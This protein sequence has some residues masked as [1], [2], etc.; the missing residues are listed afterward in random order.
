M[1]REYVQ[2][3]INSVIP[4][5]K[6]RRLEKESHDIHLSYP[7]DAQALYTPPPTMSNIDD[8]ERVGRKRTGDV[9]SKNAG[10][11]AT[12]PSNEAPKFPPAFPPLSVR[13]L[14]ERLGG[15][16]SK[17]RSRSTSPIK[18]RLD[19][20]RLEK[21]VRIDGLEDDESDTLPPDIQTL[22][23]QLLLID[24]P[25]HGGDST[26][27]ESNPDAKTTAADAVLSQI[28]HIR[29]Q[30]IASTKYQ[31]H[32]CGWNNR[33][34][35][36]LLELAFESE[37]DSEEQRR[38]TPSVRVEPAMF[39][40][41]ARDSIPR[42][43]KLF[44]G[45]DA[46]SVLAWSAS[47]ESTS[48]GYSG[49]SDLSAARPNSDS[50]KVDYIVVADVKKHAPLKKVILELI[51]S[52]WDGTPAHVNQTIYP[53]VSESLIA[54]SIET[55]TVSSSR[56]PLLQLAIWV[57]A[58]HQRMYHLR[59]VRLAQTGPENQ[60]VLRLASV[61]LIVATDHDWDVYFACDEGSS[62]VL[63]GPLRIGSTA[64]EPQLLLLINSLKAIKSWIQ[65]GFYRTMCE[66]FVCDIDQVGAT[67]PGRAGATGV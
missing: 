42:L 31:R 40:S 7:Y 27:I 30:A 3:W 67:E 56:D 50:K 35:T 9:L 21:P 57:A 16:A 62:I 24:E 65:T 22:H 28:R 8:T 52:V 11:A 25:H 10:I 1:S 54:V 48:T 66:W 51:L 6:R 2:D 14:R 53:A 44:I 61:P 17:R 39:A 23:R 33:V 59:A 5:P 46:G 36:P 38:W 13:G 63:R 45:S 19:L 15:G 58:W 47:E 55:K 20:Q 34:H 37:P 29:H 32:E 12:P 49:Q 26:S 60:K 64:T 43:G 4:S 41:I 18:G